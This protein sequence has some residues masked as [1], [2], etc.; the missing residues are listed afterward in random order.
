M[1]SEVNF[2]LEEAKH[3]IEVIYFI[4]TKYRVA[5]NKR[6]ITF[7]VINVLV[8]IRALACPVL[9]INT[10]IDCVHHSLCGAL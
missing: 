10:V 9:E 3:L 6:P 2:S 1:P 5:Q 4:S 7:N 8:K